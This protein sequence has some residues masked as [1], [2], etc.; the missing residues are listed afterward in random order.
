MTFKA[1]TGAAAAALLSTTAAYAQE[2]CVVGISMYT[3]GAP[4]FAAQEATARETAEAAGCE[5]RSADG[6][7]TW[8]SRSPISRTWLP[9]A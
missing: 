6:R 4:Y 7:T 2:G 3:L 8:S 9:R 5:V 1:L